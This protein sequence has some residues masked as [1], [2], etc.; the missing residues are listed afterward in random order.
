MKQILSVLFSLFL[1]VLSALEKDLVFRMDFDSP[2]TI[3]SESLDLNLPKT[4]LVPGKF[5]NG[6]YFQKSAFNFLHPDAAEP[7]DEKWFRP[8]EGTALSFEKEDGEKIISVSGKAFSIAETPVSLWHRKIFF[9]TP[10]TAVTFSA[11]VKGPAGSKVSLKLAFVPEKVADSRAAALFKKYAGSKLINS[12][13]A[14]ASKFRPD[15][16]GK[17]E[18]LLTGTW[19]R[20]AVYA[21]ADVRS[22]EARNIRA[23][24]S[25]EIVSSGKVRFKKMQMEHTM[26]YPYNTFQPTTFLPGKSARLLGESGVKLSLDSIRN[27]FPQKEG[28]VSF[29]MK[30]PPSSNLQ[31]SAAGFFCFGIGWRKPMWCVDNGRIVA[32]SKETVYLKKPGMTFPEWTHFALTW[33]EDEMIVYLNGKACSSEE[34]TFRNFSPSGYFFCVGKNLWSER[35]ADAVMDEFLIFSRRLKT[36]EIQKLATAE[37]PFPSRTRSASSV[38]VRPFAV[39]RFFRNDPEAGVTLEVQSET[40]QRVTAELI[41]DFH[42]ET[43]SVSLKKGSNSFKLAFHPELK[44]PGKGTWKIRLL[45]DDGRTLYENRGP[46]TVAGALRKDLVRIVSWGGEG[47][48]PFDYEKKLGINARN[49]MSGAANEIIEN[50]MM[51]SLDLR[52]HREL[53]KNNFDCARTAAESLGDL[54][55]IRDS[56]AWY[57]TILNSESIGSWQSRVWTQYPVLMQDARKALGFDPPVSQIRCNPDM[58]LDRQTMSFDD[59][60]VF[61]PGKAWKTLFW[62]RTRGDR[63]YDLNAADAKMV[64]SLRPDN[65]TWTDPAYPGLFRPLDMGSDWAY[66]PALQDVAGRLRYGWS[67][68]EVYGKLYQPTLTMYYW[69]NNR[70]MGTL[71]GKT[72]ILPRSTDELTADCWAAL[73]CAPVHDLCFFNTYAWYDA[74]TDSKHYLPMKGMSEVFGRFMR[75]DFYPAALLLRNMAEPPAHVALFMPEDISYYSEH[76]WNYYRMRMQWL[77]SLSQNNIHFDFV[78]GEKFRKDG[79]GQY[80]TVIVPMR[81]K[82]SETV[83]A[84][85]IK[86]A[87]KARIV[88]D[89]YCPAE[90]PNMVK[91]NY[92]W[93]GYDFKSFSICNEFVKKLAGKSSGRSFTAEGEKGPV[94]T[95]EKIHQG[96]RYFIVI[97]NHW[98]ADGYLARCAKQ[99]QMH[100]LD[101]KP[102]GIR[103]KVRLSFSDPAGAA[104]YDFLKSAELKVRTASG[105]SSFDFELGPGEGKVFCVYPEK[106]AALKLA[107]SGIAK[108]GKPVS[109]TAELLNPSGKRIPGRQMLNLSLRDPHGNQM[110]E[111]GFYP[112]ENGFVK[113]PVFIA[114]DAAPGRWEAEITERTTGFR[115]LLTFEVAK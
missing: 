13:P 99:K 60:G 95:F 15:I 76:D 82:A 80:H 43:K 38:R 72:Y 6:Y 5:G 89:D 31:A 53:P 86:A 52:N 10:M 51:L 110:D 50:G 100:G 56:F 74:E 63:I 85:L 17:Q 14:F 29:F 24:G 45:S 35:S 115:Q 90:Y 64:K 9:T 4:G 46:Y 55:D 107:C 62:Y 57:S 105:S 97:N 54:G 48:V 58:C 65:L 98:S 79:L 8:A 16:P 71:N 91:L 114:G 27:I 37:T 84:A 23:V 70:E 102:Y 68:A 28:T 20:I 7:C 32:G 78:A 42:R 108:R 59:Q 39:P 112:M 106:I 93:A 30:T 75:N 49:G 36:A 2:V 47:A 88:V 67:W 22:V 33:S 21:Q 103:Q 96:I 44:M 19:Q 81:S 26:F 3:G 34:R 25:A 66:S 41:T 69:I 61:Q 87:R 12:D 40:D 92:R 101:Y 109:L 18:F 94:M 104:V 113:I 11:W 83:H 77:R 73:G 1:V 111:S